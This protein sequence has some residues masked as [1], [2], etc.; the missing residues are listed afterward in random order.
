MPSRENQMRKK[1]A[2]RKLVRAAK[3]A[4]EQ[5]EFS[6]PRADGIEWRRAPVWDEL[7]EA[8]RDAEKFTRLQG[9]R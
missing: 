3:H 5:P 2:I 1:N 4:L 6:T 7:S 8:V 9:R